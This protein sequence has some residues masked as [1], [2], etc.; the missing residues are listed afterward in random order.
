MAFSFSLKNLAQLWN[1]YWFKETSPEAL[2]AYRFIIYTLGAL[3]LYF[4]PGSHPASFYEIW[5]PIS[6]YQ[7]LPGPLSTT[8]I[9]TV[10]LCWLVTSVLAGMSVGF[11]IT[12]KLA[13]LCGLFYFGYNYNFGHVYHSTHMY[14]MV[15]LIL[16]FSKLENK[17]S[18]EN[19]WP[20]ALAQAYVVYV[21]FFCGL[22][23]MYYGDGLL[24][25]FSESFYLRLLMNPA[26]PALNQWAV[27]GPLWIS[28]AMAFMGVIVVELLSPLFLFKNR[29]RWV[30]FFIWLSF[31][32]MV[33]LAYGSHKS[34]LSQVFCYVVIL[35]IDWSKIFVQLHAVK[36]L[37]MPQKIFLSSRNEHCR[38]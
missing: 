9:E 17:P 29:H 36:Q 20:L 32:F 27:D 13:A 2:K 1:S 23:K 7:L 18:I 35:P 11:R 24:W 34:F 37:L 5:D 15:L 6:F 21:M 26:T 14:V 33:M 12:G 19:R 10:K 16:S 22:Q 30:L 38:F 4:V 31:H 8:S 28:Q 3:F 25:V